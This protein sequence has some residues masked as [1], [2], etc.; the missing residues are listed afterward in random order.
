MTWFKTIVLCASSQTGQLQLQHSGT[1]ASCR[2]SPLLK[3][4]CNFDSAA[5]EKG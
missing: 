5:H 2:V 4:C 3:P 1:L